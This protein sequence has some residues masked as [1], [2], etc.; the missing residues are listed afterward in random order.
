MSERERTGERDLTYSGWHRTANMRRYLSARQAWSLGQIDI[1]WCEY[2]RYCSTPLALIE[3]QVSD[4]APKAAPVTAALA[5]MAGVPAYS[6]SIVRGD[7]DEIAL[8]K[9]QQIAPELGTVQPMIPVVY[10]YFLLS[11]RERHQ[12][13]RSGVA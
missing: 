10:A 9:V 11:F 7:L 2:C 8:F 4:R 13:T 5:R 12:C 3:T 1:D 6:L